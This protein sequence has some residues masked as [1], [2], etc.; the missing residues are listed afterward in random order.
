MLW[1]LFTAC[2]VGCDFIFL[3]L[4]TSNVILGFQWLATL[5]DSKMN[6]GNLYLHITVGG[7]KVRIQGD[8]AL[9]KSQVSLHNLVQTLK[10]ERRGILL[11]LR[12]VKPGKILIL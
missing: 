5:G 11:E 2:K 4:G 8:L 3:K 10:R 6:S 7:T 1:A 9:S 12:P